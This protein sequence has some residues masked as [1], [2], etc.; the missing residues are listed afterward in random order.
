[1]KIAIPVDEKNPDS[2]VCPSFGRTPYFAVYDTDDE[3][4]VFF[5]NEAASAQGGAGIKA[6]QLIADMDVDVL[7][8]PRCGE[9]AAEVLNKAEVRIYKTAAGTARFNIGEF[10][11]GRL[12]M[13]S[14][15]HAGLHGHAE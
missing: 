10:K 14:D 4:T 5:D 9:N 1:M 12:T 7:L 15:Y 2:S 13:L 6:A 3:K 8:S 11:A